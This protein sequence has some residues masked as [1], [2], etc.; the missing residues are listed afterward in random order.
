M[1]LNLFERINKEAKK[2]TNELA[3]HIVGDPL[4][5]SNLNDYLDISHKYDLKVNITTSANNLEEKDFVT[6]SHPSIRQIN[7]S[8]NSY[9]ANS[10]KKTVDE[11][12]NPIYD[13]CKFVLKE[14]KNFFINLRLWNFDDQKSAEQFNKLVFEKAQETFDVSLNIDDIYTNRPKN[15]K[16]ARKIFFNFDDYFE[17]PGI[18]GK[19]ISKS[20][21]CYGLN[22]HFGILANGD[23][24]PCCLDKDGIINLG[25]ANEHSI[26]K[27]LDSKRVVSIQDGF[28]KGVIVEELCQKCSFRTRF[29]NPEF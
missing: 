29:D 13:F 8:I 12:L 5:L 19:F 23:V 6:L 14:R 28:A 1:S 25:N 7:F 22:S 11:Y 18:N 24:V 2:F 15:I 17:W 26:A 9:N 4:V 10:H 27:I 16:I 21:F 3:Y 20:G